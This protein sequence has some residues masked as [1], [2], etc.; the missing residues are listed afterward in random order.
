MIE[1]VLEDGFLEIDADDLEG[2][3]FDMKDQSDD[4]VR[5]RL[6]LGDGACQSLMHYMERR[7]L[8]APADWDAVRQLSS[9]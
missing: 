9:K 3:I 1:R 8:K 7:N 5:I 6:E 4:I 2:R